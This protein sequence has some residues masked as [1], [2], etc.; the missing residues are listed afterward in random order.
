MPVVWHDPAAI[1]SRGEEPV[2]EAIAATG[3][4][5]ISDDV[6]IANV[7]LTF[8]S[9]CVANLTASR[10][11]AKRMRKLRLFEKDNYYSVDL[12]KGNIEH[13]SLI[14]E[15][16]VPPALPFSLVNETVEPVDALET[17]Q[18]AFIDV[19]NGTRPNAG[20]TGAEALAILRV[21][22]AILSRIAARRVM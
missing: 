18:Q 17:E 10:F 8:P 16:V 1:V 4:P 5:V 7:R 12:N 9:G 21:T 15:P 20:V 22:D 6:D 14:R 13:Y 19:I 2:Y 3:V 11:S